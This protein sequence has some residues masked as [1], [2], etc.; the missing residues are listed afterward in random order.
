MMKEPKYEF[1]VEEGVEDVAPI[2]RKINKTME[3]TESFN[4]Y[5]TLAYVMKMEKAVADKEAEIEGMKSM[6]KAYK[7]EI[8]LIEEKLGL[9]EM[10]R[11]WNLELHE[12]LVAET[13]EKEEEVIIE[14]EKENA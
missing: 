12:K 3:V 9:T 14:D 11:V 6:I 10:E 1:V 13:K 8:E 2:R 7:D 5:D 4:Y